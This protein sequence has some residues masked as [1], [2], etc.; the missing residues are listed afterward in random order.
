MVHVLTPYIQE[1]HV[2]TLFVINELYQVSA[3]RI[4]LSSQLHQAYEPLYQS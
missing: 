1:T 3:P 2:S 4:Y